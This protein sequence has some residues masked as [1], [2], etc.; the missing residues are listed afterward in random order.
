[1]KFRVE[2]VSVWYAN[3][4]KTNYVI[5][6]DYSEL[7]IELS[8]FPK[9]DWVPAMQRRRL[10][11]LAKISL[12]CAHNTTQDINADIP[13]VFSSR[14]GDLHKTQ[15]LLA[16]VANS[17][18]LSPASFGLS[19]HN[20]VSGLYS[21]LHNNMQSMNAVS[22]GKDTLMMGII[23]AYAKLKTGQCDKILLVHSDQALPNPYQEFAD[24]R[25][26][27]HSIAMILSLVDEQDDNAQAT[28]SISPQARGIENQPKAWPMALDF[29]RLLQGEAAQCIL[30]GQHNDWIV[31]KYV[32]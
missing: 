11:P 12:Y 18:E 4:S 6:D 22:A 14:H 20:A 25:Q 32:A 30:S 13:A 8:M 23:D 10:S 27:D 16:C 15:A 1:M 24:E 7:P 5:S 3:Q 19:V 2:N 9:L 28:I 21:I 29:I 26:L 17:Q 31:K